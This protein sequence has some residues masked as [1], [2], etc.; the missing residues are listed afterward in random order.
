[1]RE[2]KEGVKKN[3]LIN[4]RGGIGDFI[5]L[6]PLLRNIVESKRYSLYFLGNTSVKELVDGYFYFK[7]KI[8]INEKRNLFVKFLYLNNKL[9]EFKN[10]VKI[11]F[12]FSPICSFGKFVYLISILSGA[13]TRIGFKRGFLCRLIYSELSPVYNQVKDLDQNLKITSILGIEDK[14]RDAEIRISEKSE[15]L[16]SDFFSANRINPVDKVLAVAPFAK[17]VKGHPSKEWP[18]GRYDQLL[19]RISEKY[20]IKI[21]FL[22]VANELERAKLFVSNKVFFQD[23][24]FSI[25]EA[26]AIIKR[27]T[28]F[29]SIDNGLMHVAAALN[30]PIVSL[31]GPTSPERWG[32]LNR[33]SFVAIWPKVCQCCRVRKGLGDISVDD[34]LHAVDSYLSKQ[35]KYK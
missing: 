28:L 4:F 30:I 24:A 3:I 31:W 8:F 34:V 7:E 9:S 5:L 14:Y 23:S 10:R 20:D 19:K 32:Y 1:M 6:T 22:G 21:I 25:F 33:D 12:C 2:L 27:S 26:A 17:G 15:R 16:V 18:L 35:G 29:L 11:D 13:P